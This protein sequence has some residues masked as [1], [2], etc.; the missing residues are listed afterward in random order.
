MI[1]LLSL[2]GLMACGEKSPDVEDN[3]TQIE[4]ANEDSGTDTDE[5]DSP[6]PSEIVLSET[7]LTFT[8][9][10]ETSVIT[11]SVLD[12]FGESVNSASVTWEVS[13]P[14]SVGVSDD[15]TVTAINNGQVTL[16]ARLDS[17]QATAELTVLQIANDITVS[18]AELLFSSIGEGL[19]VTA[20][21]LDDESY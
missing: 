15:G 13:D 10:G 17:L 4:P 12:Q 19:Q 16:T 18:P 2:L 8:Y 7:S 6:I 11:A 14:N 21:V 5:V 9:L 20:T 1:S 3:A